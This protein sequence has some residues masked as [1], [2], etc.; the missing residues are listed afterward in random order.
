MS[1]QARLKVTVPSLAHEK[2]GYPDLR[3]SLSGVQESP[4]RQNFLILNSNTEI[5]VD[6]IR[7]EKG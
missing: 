2:R 3:G 6:D 1:D 5:G 7:I 4:V